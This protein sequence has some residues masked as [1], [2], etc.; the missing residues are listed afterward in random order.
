VT[1][2]LDPLEIGGENSHHRIDLPELATHAWSLHPEI[3]T[4][5]GSMDEADDVDITGRGCEQFFPQAASLI[6]ARYGRDCGIPADAGIQEPWDCEISL[7]RIP[8]FAGM[9]N[10]G[11]RRS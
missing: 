4:D 10:R 11:H 5:A 8:P 9:T 6:P 7:V 3:C 1:S 2:G